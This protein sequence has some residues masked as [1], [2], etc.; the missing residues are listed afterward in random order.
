MGTVSTRHII[1]VLNHSRLSKAV[2]EKMVL[3]H[4][5]HGCS[6]DF[7]IH[8]YPGLDGHSSRYD[9]L[10]IFFLLSTVF[11]VIALRTTPNYWKLNEKQRGQ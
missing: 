4:L 11:G 5:L 2:L 1:T 3:D 6:V 8:I 9:S 7:C 10:F